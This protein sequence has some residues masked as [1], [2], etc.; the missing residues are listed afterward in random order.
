M[1]LAKGSLTERRTQI[2]MAMEVGLVGTDEAERLEGQCA[3]IGLMLGALIKFRSPGN[4][5]IPIRPRPS[6]F[7]S[8]PHK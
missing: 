4:Q 1:Y 6:P 8:S 7:A 3:E 5:P 2:E